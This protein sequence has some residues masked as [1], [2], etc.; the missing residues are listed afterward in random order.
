[1]GWV[2]QDMFVDG[3]NH[4]LAASGQLM[5]RNQFLAGSMQH[6]S[7]RCRK[8]CE[9][10]LNVNYLGTLLPEGGSVEHVQTEKT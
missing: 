10:H 5:I 4:L 7:M 2:P 8:L 6:F 9:A 1:M 3:V